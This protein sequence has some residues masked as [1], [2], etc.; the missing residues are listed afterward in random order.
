MQPTTEVTF[1]HLSL[2]AGLAFGLSH[3]TLPQ[4]GMRRPVNSSA[5]PGEL[6]GGGL[7]LVKQ[8]LC[9]VLHLF[10]FL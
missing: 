10:P 2:V 1:F 9:L 8:R 3:A 7:K 5:S 4:T 6:G